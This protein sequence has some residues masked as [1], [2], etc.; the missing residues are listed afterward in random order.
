MAWTVKTLPPDAFR[1]ECARLEA[2]VRA[3]GFVP[4]VVLGICSGGK[5]VADEMFSG[6][7]HVYT[8]L[9]RPL[10]SGKQH[11]GWLLGLLPM[12]MLDHLRIAEARMLENQSRKR[13]F[14]PSE[15][16]IPPLPECGKI[17]VVDDAVDSGTTLR[18][19]IEKIFSKYPNILLRSA[20]ITNTSPYSIIKPD[21]TL[22]DNNTLIRF[23]WSKD[24]P[25]KK[26]L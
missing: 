10:T 1:D 13:D 24:M 3:D 8:V 26:R 5:Y 12:W 2:R 19:V 22:Y 17:L 11:V 23:P 21:Y 9:Q 14:N 20:V 6:V 25:R 15:V 7:P 4:D 18:S 16:D